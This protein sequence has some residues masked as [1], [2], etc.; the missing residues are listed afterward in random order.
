MKPDTKAIEIINSK[1]FLAEN[2]LFAWSLA[3]G[4]AKLLLLINSTTANNE[5][6]AGETTNRKLCC[7]VPT[8]CE[9]FVNK[10]RQLVSKN[11]L[12]TLCHL[13]VKFDT[14]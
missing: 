2:S 3:I 13:Q 1:P 11:M 14:D 8:C 6:K 12:N 4:S 10:Q 7:T 9:R 5:N